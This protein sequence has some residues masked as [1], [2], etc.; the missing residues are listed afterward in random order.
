MAD[1]L[2]ELWV[3]IEPLNLPG[4]DVIHRAMHLD[5]RIV[6]RVTVACGNCVP[7]LPI[8][9]QSHVSA[10][11]QK[12]FD[13]EQQWVDSEYQWVL[14]GPVLHVDR[15]VQ[16]VGCHIDSRHGGV[17]WTLYPVYE[18]VNYASAHHGWRCVA[19]V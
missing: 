9:D 15:T 8:Q 14:A 10:N 16:T 13:S 6:V 5:T 4:M 12:M 7:I 18:D 17:R 19:L 3:L 11:E 1:N 2:R